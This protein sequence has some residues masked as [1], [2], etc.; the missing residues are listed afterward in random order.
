MVTGCFGSKVL[1][2]LSPLVTPKSKH[3]PWASSCT[4]TPRNFPYVSPSLMMWVPFIAQKQHE[5]VRKLIFGIKTDV[6]SNTRFATF[7]LKLL[8]V[9][10]TSLNLHFFICITICQMGRDHAQCSIEHDSQT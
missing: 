9:T 2:D 5:K 10:L 7:S 1:T 6:V 3:L 8:N 4:H